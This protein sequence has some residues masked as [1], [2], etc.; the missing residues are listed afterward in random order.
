MSSLI[1]YTDE[2]QALV[3]FDTLVVSPDSKEALYFATRA[4]YVPHL[5]TII[6]STGAPR[7]MEQWFCIVNQMPVGDIQ[8][9]NDHTQG[10]LAQLFDWFSSVN[11]HRLPEEAVIYHTGISGRD[12]KIH[13]FA[14]SS[15][16]AFKPEHLAY[17]LAIIPPCPVPEGDF[18]FVDHVPALMM[19]QR[20]EQG[21]VEADKRIYIGGE[22][23]GMYLTAEGCNSFKLGSFDDYPADR[24][25][26]DARRD[27]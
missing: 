9:L 26:I 15:S 12:E 14:Y 16:S 27:A 6:A 5:R 2:K 24:Q 13:S 11:D 8:D 23:Y 21:K 3:A 7:F 10:N 25:K 19:K 4:I 1:V 22:I 18:R 20:E 17:G